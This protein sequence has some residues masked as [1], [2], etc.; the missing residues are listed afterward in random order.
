MS[1]KDDKSIEY[2]QRSIVRRIGSKLVIY[3]GESLQI[4]TVSLIKD[5]NHKIIHKYE[6]KNASSFRFLKKVMKTPI[7]ALKFSGSKKIN[8]LI[9]LALKEYSSFPDIFIKSFE[10]ILENNAKNTIKIGKMQKK[11]LKLF[12]GDK[13]AIKSLLYKNPRVFLEFIQNFNIKNLNCF[14][15]EIN[16]LKAGKINNKSKAIHHSF[17]LENS[18]KP[19]IPS[20]EYQ[21]II[22]NINEDK[23]CENFIDASEFYPEILLYNSFLLSKLDPAFFETDLFKREFVTKNEILILNYVKKHAKCT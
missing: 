19:G 1:M 3:N 23:I 2:K 11:I 12:I 18:M 17:C 22:D 4:I 14:R 16:I 15:Y 10:N 7:K 9:V 5:V 13:K 8:I 6:Q 21:S 20:H